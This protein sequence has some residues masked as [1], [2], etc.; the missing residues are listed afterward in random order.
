MPEL[1]FICIEDI[2]QILFGYADSFESYFVHGL[3][4]QTDEFFFFAFFL[5]LGDKYNTWKS[6]ERRYL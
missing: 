4:S 5:V 6:I 3:N 2:H 1:Y